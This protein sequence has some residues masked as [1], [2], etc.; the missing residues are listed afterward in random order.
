MNQTR[1]QHKYTVPFEDMIDH[2]PILLLLKY[3]DC[4]ATILFVLPTR[5]RKLNAQ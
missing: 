3:L 5:F 4:R 2:S 1:F